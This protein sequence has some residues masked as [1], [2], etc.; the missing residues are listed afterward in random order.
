[1]SNTA[2]DHKILRMKDLTTLIGLPRSKVYEMLN[3]K[4]P[5]HDPDFPCPVHLDQK[6]I[7]WRQS[8]VMAWLMSCPTAKGT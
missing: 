2:K 7:G 6:S 5:R 8:D 1:M 4:S 3:P